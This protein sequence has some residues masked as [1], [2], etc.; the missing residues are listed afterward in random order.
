M[1]IYI[2][3]GKKIK[4]QHHFVIKKKLQ[5]GIER[6]FFNLIKTTSEKLTLTLYKVLEGKLFP[7]KYQKEVKD[8]GICHFYLIFYWK[9][10]L[11]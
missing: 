3:L 6:D 11:E 10:Y 7:S 2:D 8:V 1:I 5:S 4:C 9:F